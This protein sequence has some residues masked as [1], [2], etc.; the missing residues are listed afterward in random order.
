M[1]KGPTSPASSSSAGAAA[2]AF[3]CAA[4]DDMGPAFGDAEEPR[5]EQVGGVLGAKVL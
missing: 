1:G 4:D 2:A 3:C 5:F